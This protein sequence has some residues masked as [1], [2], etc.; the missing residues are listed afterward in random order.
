MSAIHDDLYDSAVSK[1]R[2]TI[3][4]KDRVLLKS[5]LRLLRDLEPFWEWGQAHPGWSD[6]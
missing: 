2:I 6:F 1:K 4:K 3:L 5:L